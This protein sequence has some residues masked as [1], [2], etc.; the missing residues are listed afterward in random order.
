[1]IEYIMER[2]AHNLGKDPLD[3]RMLNMKKGDNPIPEMIEQL[4]KDANYDDRFSEI[5]KFNQNNRWRKRAIKIIP[6]TY[7]LFYFGNYNSI[8]GI[9]H[10]DGTIAI[11]HAGIEMGQGINT[12]VAQVCAHILDVPLEKISVKPSASFTS[13]NAMVT[14]G[15]IGSELVSFA[16]MRACQILADRLA[17]IRLKSKNA[18]W[19]EIVTL[20]YNAG[21]DLQAHYMY[22]PSDGVK[23]YDL[24]G[25]SALEVEVDLLTGN[26]DVLRVDILEDVGRSLS[27]EIDVGQ[28]SF[29]MQLYSLNMKSGLFL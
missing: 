29:Y 21:I 1:M 2:I 14:G 8:V 25:V 13:P 6:L 27:P 10:S 9:F 11:T 15:S 20:A 24:F 17:P 5:K 12:K 26:H 19:E 7:D 3:V 16:T 28:V 22:S 4:K 18:T 23:P